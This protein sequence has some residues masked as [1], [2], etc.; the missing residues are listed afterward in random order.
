MQGLVLGGALL[1]SAG[2]AI[3]VNTTRSATCPSQLGPGLHTIRMNVPDGSDPEFIW[4]RAFD[5]YVPAELDPNVESPT[6]LMWH[7]CGSDPEKFQEES[8]MNLRVGR[9]GYYAIW[10]RGTS[11]TLAPS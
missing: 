6:M 9:F 11:S 10:P 3:P 2:T 8:E 1:V 4:S 5:V 7:G